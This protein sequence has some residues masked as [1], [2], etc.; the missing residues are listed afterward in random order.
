MGEFQ[1]K[2]EQES[3]PFPTGIDLDQPTK[4]ELSQMLN[5]RHGF[6]TRVLG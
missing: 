1:S 4:V 6:L 2:E 3:S 5:C